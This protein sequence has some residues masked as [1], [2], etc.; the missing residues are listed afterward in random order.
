MSSLKDQKR[1]S[2]AVIKLVECIGILL[3]IPPSRD[4]SLYKAPM[5][6]NYDHVVHLLDENYGAYITEVSKMKSSMLSNKVA[7]DLFAKT[8]EPGF[9]YQQAVNDGGLTARDLFNAI[10]VVMMSLISDSS[11][12]PITRTNILVAVNGTMSSYAAMDAATHMF[13]HG[14]MTAMALTV[15]ENH[16]P[17]LTGM[18]KSHL[19]QDLVRRCKLQYKLPDH[20][21]SVE[22]AYVDKISDIT[23]TI[24]SSANINQSNLIVY[25]L[26]GDSTFGEGGDGGVPLWLA[27]AK[28]VT[29]TILLTKKSS[30]IRPFPS[31]FLPRTLLVY[32]DDTKDPTSLAALFMKTLLYVRPGDSIILCVVVEPS[33]PK[34]DG[35]VQRFEM[36]TRA[37]SWISGTDA[38]QN[39]PTSPGWNDQANKDMA[40]QMEALLLGS[41]VEGKYRIECSRDGATIGRTL[42]SI[43]AEEQIDTVVMRRQAPKETIVESVQSCA[44]SIMIA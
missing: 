37:G 36:G 13:K 12:I 27:T 15:E 14:V 31:I 26:E 34:G 35:R 17:R 39:E 16:D 30:R 40:Q 32:A 8:L 38:P 18:M 28:D 24:M 19:H 10:Q 2:L 4:K 7:N 41:Q 1:P 21:Y 29:N 9:D 23:S 25:G 22:S 33:H 43:V 42:A 3:G 6:S 5:P 44:C 11:R 20:C